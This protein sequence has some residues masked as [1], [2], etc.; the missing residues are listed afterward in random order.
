MKKNIGWE[1]TFME[2]DGS[3][4]RSCDVE[5]ATLKLAIRQ[6]LKRLNEHDVVKVCMK[7]LAQVKSIRF[8]EFKKLME[9]RDE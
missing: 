4:Y 8:A 3:G 5:V 6:A 7:D 1:I 2:P 9:D